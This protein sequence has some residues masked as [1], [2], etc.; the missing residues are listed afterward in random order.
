SPPTLFLRAPYPGRGASTIW[1]SRRCPAFAGL[2]LAIFVVNA[3]T[4]PVNDE[5]GDPADRA[6]KILPKIVRKAGVTE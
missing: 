3:E 6:V 5:L 1:P 2:R 4:V